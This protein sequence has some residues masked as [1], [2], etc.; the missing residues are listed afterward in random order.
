VPIVVCGLLFRR[1][2]KEELRSLYVISGALIVLAV[3]MVAAE[4]LVK[5]RRQSR[6]REKDMA[7]VSAL[8]A[9]LVGVCQAMALIP[10]TSRSGVTITGW[11]FL[12]LLSL[13]AVFAA[14][15]LEMVKEREELGSLGAVNVI[16]ATVVSGVVGYASIALLLRFLRTRT[17]YF[18]VVYRLLL[19]GFLLALLRSGRLTP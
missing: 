5:I 14:A 17:L 3:L 19:A 18:F 2:I 16:L 13:P 11:L 4:E 15:V 1:Q 8:D 9:F 10:G 7:G 12:G 6:T